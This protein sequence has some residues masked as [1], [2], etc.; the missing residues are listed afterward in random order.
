MSDQA[1]PIRALF[2]TRY[3]AAVEARDVEGYVSLYTP[4]AIWIRPGFAPRTGHAAIAEGFQD[5]LE[6][7]RIRATFTAEDIERHG[8][9][10]TVLGRCKAEVTPLIGE[11][12]A[13]Q[14]YA[15]LWIVRERHG[16]WLIHRQIWTP[17]L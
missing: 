9:S 3:P 6:G 1:Q 12:R 10:A 7:H 11:E 16:E 5:M 15:A 4:E 14:S 17:I 2:E 13:S 8:G